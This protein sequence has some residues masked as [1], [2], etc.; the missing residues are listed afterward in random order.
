MAVDYSVDKFSS[1]ILKLL[2]NS[3][4]TNKFEKENNSFAK[5]RF[6]KNKMVKG[7]RQVYN[8]L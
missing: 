5:K 2:K 7:F 6:N 8:S 1:I 3:N 4:I